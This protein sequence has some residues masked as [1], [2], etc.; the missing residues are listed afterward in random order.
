LLVVVAIIGV[1]IGLLLPAVQAAREAARRAQCINHLKQIGLAVHNFHDTQSGLPPSMI[2]AM[3]AADNTRWNRVTIWPLIYPFLEQAQL[4]EEY[5]SANFN[6]NTGF[7]VWFSNEWWNLSG[8]NTGGLNEEKR[9]QHGSVSILRCPT[10][11]GGG[12]LIV[13]DF[14][15]TSADTTASSVAAG[16]QGDYCPVLCMHKETEGTIPAAVHWQIG[17]EGRHIPFDAGPFRQAV[18]INGNGNTWSPRDTMAWWADGSSNQVLFAEKH[19]RPELI[20]KCSNTGDERGDCSIL[21][22]G[23]IRRYSSMR[24]F[25]VRADNAA[26]P[27][28]PLPTTYKNFAKVNDTGLDAFGS[29]HPG[30]CNC[31]FGDGSIFSVSITVPANPIM[32][33]FSRVNDGVSVALP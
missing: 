11:R 15:A 8:T 18:L 31:L 30:V 33:A 13:T 3:G 28:T 12:P 25:Y 14:I 5:N 10:R 7:N 16:P 29:T 20:G 26:S 1:L 21:N 22:F 2:G 24:F 27:V 17:N 23:E 9:K 4:Y 6:G 32:A 19:I